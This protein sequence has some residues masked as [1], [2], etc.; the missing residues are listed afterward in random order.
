MGKSENKST[1]P[2]DTAI[3]SSKS[4]I[5]IFSESMSEGWSKFS[6]LSRKFTGAMQEQVQKRKEQ[7]RNFRPASE[8][9]K[10]HG[11]KS[12]EKTHSSDIVST[13]ET[14]SVDIKSSEEKPEVFTVD[15]DFTEGYFVGDSRCNEENPHDSRKRLCYL[16]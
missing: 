2:V 15:P 16:Y 11:Q 4:R 12:N 14:T 9:D 10:E 6:S 5:S 8:Q 13:D 3:S 1:K 7:F